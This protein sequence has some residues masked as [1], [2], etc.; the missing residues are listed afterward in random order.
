MSQQLWKALHVLQ[1]AADSDFHRQ[2]K[3]HSGRFRCGEGCA[4]CCRTPFA[5]SEA[6]AAAISRNVGLLPAPRCD[7]LR[8]RAVEYLD[9]RL[10]VF[11][12]YGYRQSRGELAPEPERVECPALLNGRCSIYA[13]RP[14]LCRRFGAALIH[15]G[16][17]HRAF[18]C[19]LNF[20][21]GEL[22]DDRQIIARQQ[23]LAQHAA[24]LRRAYVQA[25]G[26]A[27]SEPITVAHALLEDFQ[28]Y[29][30]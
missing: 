25:G 10:A 12:Q 18:A 11:S 29:L 2:R 22:I 15:P 7:E 20:A 3:Q 16:D 5:I 1:D 6:E 24:G 26:R 21:P 9:R 27:Y 13:H 28:A 30:P 14:V 23:E 8:I 17:A 4:A 19:Q